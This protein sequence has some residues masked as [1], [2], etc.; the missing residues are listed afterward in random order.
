MFSMTTASTLNSLPREIIESISF[1][2]STHDLLQVILVSKSW[3]RLFYNFIYRSLTIDTY[4]KQEV[5]LS[6]FCTGNL[7]GHFVKA[8]TLQGIDLNEYET[9][10]LTKLFPEVDTLI[11]NWNIW[12]SS[13]QFH[14]YF[15]SDA[16][17]S[18]IHPPQGLP[19]CV[20]Q[21][22]CFYG[23]QNLR[24]LSIDAA[25]QESTDLW[26][27]LASCP[28]L[29]SLKLLNLNHEHIIT[30]GYLETIHQLCP[31][32]VE[33]TIKCTRS[34]PN[35]AL[36]SQFSE[37]QYSLVLTPTVL[38][39]FSLASKSGSA[40]WPYWLPYFS[41]KYPHLQH[42]QF[43]HCGLGKDGGGN[44]IVPDQV[45]MSFKHGCRQLKSVRWNKI[46]VRHDQQKGLF[47]LCD[48]HH[49]KQQVQPFLHLER[50]EAYENF[51]IPSSIQS[52]PLVQGN[53]LMS[54]LLTSLTIGQPPADVAT[55]QVLE[56]IGHCKNL[57]SLKIQEC[58][59]DPEIAYDMDNILN[60]CK[61]L[62]T[63]YIKDVHLK[64][65][66]AR[67][68]ILSNHPLKKLKLKR[69]SFDE[70]VFD[71]VSKACP[72][73]DHV[74]LLGCFQ[75]DRRDQV[76]ILLPRQELTTLKIQGLRTRQYFAGCRIRFFQVNQSWYYM[77]QYD[78]RT[79]L[80]GQKLPFQ[81]YRN[82]EFAHT[83]DRLEDR[84]IQ[85]LKLLVTTETLKAWDIEAVKRNLQTPS[86][87]LDASFWDP[88]NLYYS[89]FVK[90]EFK[91][92]QHLLINNKLLL[93]K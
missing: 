51:Q 26:S 90:I 56:A 12:S 80:V 75:R 17:I 86:T 48:Q 11:F 65:S 69:A 85:E 92:V 39:S 89:G 4:E 2:I 42:V 55:V 74:E 79:H 88:E 47:S 3:Y 93:L 29:K 31:N 8:L 57:V 61:H 83:F 28:R 54:S 66:S 7:P 45:F 13:L 40:K 41:V 62:H 35:P 36:L 1:Y 25:N 77:S 37:D 6:A 5:I 60:H 19:P 91:S 32:L 15:D 53:S 52:S 14:A 64:T 21:L 22:F 68:A 87:C 30:L 59:V 38:Q 67:K 70:G 46:I 76:R 82:M 16:P 81:K 58:F 18:F 10:H 72:L 63:L 78:I 73:L 23:S 34:D 9:S 33:L 49:N 44:Q 50:I 43:K 84:D 71:I 27:I 20:G 24:N